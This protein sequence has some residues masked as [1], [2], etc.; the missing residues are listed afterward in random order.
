MDHNYNLCDYN[1]SDNSHYDTIKNVTAASAS[2]S[3]PNND[4]ETEDNY[5]HLLANMSSNSIVLALVITPL[6]SLTK[7][8]PSSRCGHGKDNMDKN[9]IANNLF[10]SKL[11]GLNQD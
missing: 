7:P 5:V 4:N 8:L 11:L 6:S 10:A 2:M 9:Y 3:I 1:T